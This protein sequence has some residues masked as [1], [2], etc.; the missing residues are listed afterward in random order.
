MNDGKKRRSSAELPAHKRFAKSR[1]RW[2]YPSTPTKNNKRLCRT[3]FY[4]KSTEPFFALTTGLDSVASPANRLS[5]RTKTNKT[6]SCSAIIL[7]SNGEMQFQKSECFQGIPALDIH[8]LLIR[9]LQ[10]Q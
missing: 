7:L 3:S 6:V 9:T 10:F 2:I 1:S 5:L 8:S 4:R